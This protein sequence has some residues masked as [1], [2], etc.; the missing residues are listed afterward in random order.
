MGGSDPLSGMTGLALLTFL[1]NYLMIVLYCCVMI[2]LC[3]TSGTVLHLGNVF[4]HREALK[5]GQEGVKMGSDAEVRWVTHLLQLRTTDAV[6]DA[7]TKK[8]TV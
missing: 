1:I 5:H 8:T 4:F 3:W 7:L 6:I 2:W